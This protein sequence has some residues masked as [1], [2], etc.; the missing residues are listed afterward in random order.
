MTA[1][2][3]AARALL[4]M[5]LLI[6]LMSWKESVGHIGNANFLVPAFPLVP[7]HA[8]YHIFREV[9]GDVAKMGV[10][11]LLFFGPTHWR[12]AVAWWICLVLMLGYYAPFWIGEPFLRALS[13]PIPFA[14]HVHVAMA[15]FAFVG[16]ALARPSF[17]VSTRTSPTDSPSLAQKDLQ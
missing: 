11:L 13:A 2:L 5:G 9:C 1:R 3:N 10:F 14:G 17:A 16:L 12:T 8:W 4:V 7:T 15:L 6:G